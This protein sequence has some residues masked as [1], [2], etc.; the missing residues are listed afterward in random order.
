M[1]KLFSQIIYVTQFEGV[2]IKLL[3]AR[4]ES[5]FR[6]NLNRPFYIRRYFMTIGIINSTIYIIFL[7]NKLNKGV[8]IFW[9]LIGQNV[10]WP[11][12]DPLLKFTCRR[13]LD[14]ITSTRKS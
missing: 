7:Y 12:L 13:N 10:I 2:L 3:H 9:E 4:N 6:V 5:H 14:K 8:G 11:L 1:T